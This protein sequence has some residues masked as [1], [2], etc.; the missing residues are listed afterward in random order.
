[1]VDGAASSAVAAIGIGSIHLLN[2]CAIFQHTHKHTNTTE[3]VTFHR[4]RASEMKMKIRLVAF[5]QEYISIR[6]DFRIINWG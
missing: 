4:L 1:M 5:R 2:H 6:Y 3:M